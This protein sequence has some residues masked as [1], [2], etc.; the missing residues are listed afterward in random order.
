[1]ARR[2]FVWRSTAKGNNRLAKLF[3]ILTDE[4]VRPMDRFQVRDIENGSLE[5]TRQKTSPIEGQE[6]TG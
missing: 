3:I 6:T 2:E 5:I 1:M 4:S